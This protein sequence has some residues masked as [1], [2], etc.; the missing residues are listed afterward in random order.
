[1]RLRRHWR[2]ALAAV[3]CCLSAC[4]PAGL[5][6]QTSPDDIDS[7][8]QAYPVVITPT[9]LR[10]SLADV[11]A[12]VTVIT[13]EM[14]RRYGIASV[15][16]AL[17]LVPGM[18]VL[19]AS[20]NDFRINYHGTNSVAPRRFN[21]LVDGVSV[22]RPALSRVEWA[23]LPVAME[24]IDHIEVIRGPDSS[25]YGPNSMT[26]VVNILTKHPKDV[27]RALLVVSGDSRDTVETTLRLAATLG[28]TSVRATVSTERSKGYDRIRP[29]PR[30]DAWR[31]FVSLS[32]QHIGN[33]DN[34]ITRLNLRAQSDLGDGSSLELQASHAGGVRG[35]SFVDAYQISDP[36]ERKSNGQ[37]SARWTKALSAEHE[38][39]V[40]AFHAVTEIRQP[41][42]T[43][44][45]Q[46]A[47]LPELGALFRANPGY[48]Q[49]LLSGRL[50]S[51]GT[52]EDNALLLQLGVA[53]LRLGLGNALQ[54]TC[55][56]GNQDISESRTQFEV[57]DTYVASST[58][59]FVG[60][61]GF[62]RQR[63]TSETLFGGSAGNSVRWA[64]GHAEYRPLPWLTANVGGYGE[65]NS[66]SGSTFSPRVALNL[67]LSQA[68]TLRAVF[69]KGTR[70]TDLLEERG[71]L[72]GTLTN[73]TVPV[74]GS[75]TARA[76][77][78]KRSDGG[79]SSE[80]IVSRELG[81]LL[82]LPGAGVTL[83]IKLFND[84]LTQLVSI[85]S[86]PGLFSLIQEGND[87]S[88]TL[89]GA[90]AQLQWSLSPNW[91]SWLS[92]SYLEN[93][94]ASASTEI[95]QYARHSGAVG[96]S[97]AVSNDWGGSLAY[98]GASGNGFGEERYGRTDLTLS[99]A[100]R[101][102][103]GP[104]ALSMTLSYLDH[105][106]VSVPLTSLSFL[107]S[108]YDSRLSLR[109]SVRLAF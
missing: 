68:Q 107:K 7:T 66:L 34:R 38:L 81:Y 48:V 65:S 1:M 13:S 102:P 91:S 32:P 70:T 82:S 76:F 58:L 93:R 101:I 30:V 10:Q 37:V 47:L 88:V 99:R 3:P 75:T 71:N 44:L 28:R 2:R 20:G 103:A 4:L 83:D 105:P 96:L 46:A 59:R 62:R 15:P 51:G 12:S 56:T 31:G 80:R 23:W 92:Y 39:Q 17:R 104:G 50:P 36:D 21:V 6:A 97:Y 52:A 45:P 69:S 100:F 41:W 86:D 9:R 72:S 87:D 109:G 60:G 16:D 84:R 43:C 29:L 108:S 11:P 89:R 24:D 49:A 35:G 57:Q 5:W 95:V 18:A 63:A 54:P 73:L 106:V 26:A 78:T 19:Q 85:R 8:E 22:Y 42:M 90:E 94:D 27:E 61:L 67:R 14:I 77:L 53:L 55:G 33:D 79:L 40:S 64:F 25:S 98:V 74:Q